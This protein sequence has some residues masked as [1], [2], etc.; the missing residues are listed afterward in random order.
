M[1]LQKIKNNQILIKNT[2]YLSIIEIIRLV[3]PFVALPYIIKTVGTEN[4]GLAIFAQTIISYFS[5]FINFGL[6]ISALKD[7]SINRDNKEKLSKIVSAVL[8]IKSILFVISVV[9]LL[10]ILHIIPFLK[11]HKLLFLYAFLACF[12]ELLFPAWFYQG[13]EKM[14]YI[15]IIRTLSIILYTG[16]VFL[17]IHTPQDYIK[18]VLLQSLS[19]LLAGFVSLYL[20]IHIESIK[21]LK[22]DRRLLKNIFKESI[23]FF[24]SRL[25]VVLNNTM[26]KTVSGIFFSMN[27]VAAFDIAQKVATVSLV[28]MQM[29]NQAVFPKIAQTLSKQF[30]SKFL[31]LNVCISFIVAF[32]VFLFAPMAIRFFAGDRMPEAVTLIRILSIWVFAGGITT[33][34]GAPVLVSF[35][36]PKQFNISVILSTLILLGCYGVLYIGNSFT[37]YMFA[38]ALAASELAILAYRWYYCLQFEIIDLNGFF[39]IKGKI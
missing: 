3:M 38:M 1:L 34:L 15:T 35:G 19:H 20:L 16:S 36:Y 30:V 9:V 7:V 28:P 6:D 23:P 24:F 25:S 17:F 21:L 2:G 27:I 33:Y 5:I 8:S 37:I 11:V 39:R 10:L 26:A 18:I 14:K 4:Y 12:S 32:F 13:I 22:V 29:M 31:K